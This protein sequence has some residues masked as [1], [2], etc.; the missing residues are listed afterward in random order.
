MQMHS[1]VAQWLDGLDHP[2]AQVHE[3]LSSALISANQ[4]T[5][6]V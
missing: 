3:P 6:A 5:D 1:D 2:P 4:L